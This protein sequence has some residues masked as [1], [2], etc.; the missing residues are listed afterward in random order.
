[1]APEIARCVKTFRDSTG[2]CLAPDDG[3][4]G[5]VFGSGLSDMARRLVGDARCVEFEKLE[6]FPSPG[7]A[8]HSGSFLLGRLGETLLIAQLGRF[9]PYEGRT[10][11]EICLGVEL[12]AAL[13][14]KNLILTNAAGALNP[15]FAPG[16]LMLMTDF[17]NHSGLSPLTGRIG[18][19]ADPFPDMSAPF[20][21]KL[22][23]LVTQVALN[24]KIRLYEGVYIGVH[25]PEMETRAETRMYRQWGADAIGMSTVL[26]IIAAR[27][28]GMRVLGISC[29]SN[30]NLPDCMKPCG[31]DEILGEAARAGKKLEKLLSALLR[32]PSLPECLKA[33]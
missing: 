15:I 31:F 23:A 21:E 33:A 6:G 2:L 13:G 16:G 8:S 4:L 17:I 30:L 10:A 12:M 3:G 22:S 1:M 26:E 9:H 20:D 28:F 27:R 29:L 11:R 7:V 5:I 19:F 25:G 14:F 32:C 18:E 24:E